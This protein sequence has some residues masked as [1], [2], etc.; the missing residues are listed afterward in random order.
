MVGRVRDPIRPGNE[1]LSAAAVALLIASVSIDDRDQVGAVL[2]QARSQ[3]HHE[4]PFIAVD[5]LVLMP[6]G[7]GRHEGERGSEDACGGTHP[8]VT[9]RSNSVLMTE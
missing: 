1:E 3:L 9:T 5:Q 6:G 7:G 4:R 8:G 2:T